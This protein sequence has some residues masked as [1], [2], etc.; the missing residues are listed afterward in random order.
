MDELAGKVAVV[1]GGASGIGLALV[2]AFLEEGMRV[3]AADVEAAALERAVADLPEGAEVEAVVCDVSD[4]AQVDA[5]RD[6]AVE[7]FGTVH[8]VCNNAGVSAGAPVW[9]HSVEDWEWVLGVN[10][11]G[12][13]HGIRAFT[14]LLIEQGE[15]HVVNTASMAGLTSMP[16]SAI[17]NV[18][19]HGVVT[20]SETLF[21]DLAMV[22]ASGV[23]VSVLCPGW[24]QTRIHE[25]G[26][27]RPEVAGGDAVDED[28]QRAALRAGFAEYI[29]GVIA[30]GLDPADVA[31]LVVDAIRTDRFYVLT[32]PEWAPMITGRTER[33]ARG[34]GPRL[35]SL[36]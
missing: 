19:K 1:T 10:L 20:L 9:E 28:P 4:G 7:R 36:P 5:L 35:P 24:V 12:V 30:S 21:A 22:G 6:R 16:F 32:H 13:I 34:D 18:S 33:I 17:Y 8:V 3:V 11:W 26:R 31:A 25:A 2:R 29:A 27:N 15:G 14:P 23:G